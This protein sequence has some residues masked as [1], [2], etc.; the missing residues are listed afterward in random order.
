[1]LFNLPQRGK[2]VPAIVSVVTKKVS[3][4]MLAPQGLKLSINP[5][6][7]IQLS[8]Q[9]NFDLDIFAYYI[10]RGTSAGNMRIISSAIKDTVFIDSL[11]TLNAGITYLYSVAAMNMDMKW[12]D[13]SAPVAMQSTRSKLIPAPGGIQARASATGIR[14]SWNDISVSDPSVTGYF[15]YRR[16]KGAPYFTQLNKTPIP[17]TYYTDTSAMTAGIYEYGCSSVD[18]WNH[19][20]ILSALAEVDSKGGIG[21]NPL[22]PPADFSLRNLT[23]GIEIRIPSAA[24]AEG[25]KMTAPGNSKYI[26]YRRLVTEKSFQKVGVLAENNMAYTD[27]QVV[28]DQLY[29]YTLTLQLEKTESSRSME[30][31]I[32]RK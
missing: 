22:Y 11:K 15:L 3:G 25:E 30:K 21:S 26:V 19:V 17:G 14:L 18:A 4:K 32:R 27:K 8:W 29:A 13:T 12:S 6:K 2:V 9:P 16:K 20:S 31:S 23:T 24:V 7:N 1:M 5:D 28:K 10:L